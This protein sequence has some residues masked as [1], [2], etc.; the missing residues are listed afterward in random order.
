MP[1][2][3]PKAMPMRRAPR[4]EASPQ[5]SPPPRWKPT[6]N[7]L[8]PLLGIDITT[9][10]ELAKTLA[11]KAL[12]HGEGHVINPILWGV[13]LLDGGARRALVEQCPFS[14]VERANE[15]WRDRLLTLRGEIVNSFG[16]N[17]H[18]VT[19]RKVFSAPS[20]AGQILGVR[21]MSSALGSEE[22]LAKDSISLLR[23]GRTRDPSSRHE[24]LLAVFPELPGRVLGEVKD[25]VRDV[26]PL[27]ASLTLGRLALEDFAPDLAFIP[28][29]DII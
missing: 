23:N 18:T 4:G 28:A 17:E 21:T 7:L 19:V 22:K 27:D 26:M 16:N 1:R 29:S 2:P 9:R 11:G 20:P 3:T 8:R 6:Q 15:W 25:A 12:E 14:D 5:E 13:P 24:M 10:L